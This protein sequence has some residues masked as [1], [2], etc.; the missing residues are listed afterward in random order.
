[1]HFTENNITEY[2]T[3]FK[4]N[5]LNLVFSFLRIQDCDPLCE[6][7]TDCKGTLSLKFSHEFFRIHNPKNET[8]TET[9]HTESDA[10]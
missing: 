3:C 5:A 6:I 1:M 7:Q 2:F 8:R 9:L 4:Q 10:Y